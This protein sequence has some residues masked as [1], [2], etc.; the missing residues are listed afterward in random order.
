MIYPLSLAKGSI[1]PIEDRASVTSVQKKGSIFCT[2]QGG[3]VTSDP[4]RPNK[5]SPERICRGQEAT[6]TS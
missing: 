4:D 2:E 6:A 5:E 1:A 3:D